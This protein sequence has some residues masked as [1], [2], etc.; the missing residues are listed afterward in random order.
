M[1]I[2]DIEK[3][4]MEEVAVEL[5]EGIVSRAEK[6]NISIEKDAL[7]NLKEVEEKFGIR[8]RRPSFSF[9]WQ[10]G[11]RGYDFISKHFVPQEELARMK[12]EF[13]HYLD[14]SQKK[15]Q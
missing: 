11:R 12:K 9:A 6:R 14:K 7:A 15:G 13:V 8:A 10:E 3:K 1:V 4:K 2:T 5:W